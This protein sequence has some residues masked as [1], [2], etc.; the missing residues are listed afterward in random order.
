MS[1]GLRADHGQFATT[2]GSTAA[3]SAEVGMTEGAVALIMIGLFHL[4]QGF[5]ALTDGTIFVV[6]DNWMVHLDLTAWGWIHLTLGVLV[7]A[8][9]AFLF[10]G[11]AAARFVGVA[12]LAVSGLAS[13][14]WL[15]YNPVLSVLVIVMDGY[16]IWALSVHEEVVPVGE[17]EDWD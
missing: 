13:L 15:P 12:L 16:L 1:T 8:G 7:G 4:I 2:P 6:A 14:L 3:S 17:S 5:A 10:T 9:G 11:R